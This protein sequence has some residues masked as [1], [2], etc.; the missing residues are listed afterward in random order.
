MVACPAARYQRHFHRGI[1]G[2][3][4]EHQPLRAL[5]GTRVL[6]RHAG[7]AAFPAPRAQKVVADGTPAVFRTDIETK[8]AVERLPRDR[9]RANLRFVASGFEKQRETLRFFVQVGAGIARKLQ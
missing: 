9:S 7:H 2:F 4:A 5:V 8:T 3:G 1:D 6:D